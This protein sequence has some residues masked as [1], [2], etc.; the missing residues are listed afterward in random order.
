MEFLQDICEAKLFG[1]GKSNLT[2]YSA[3]Q[4]TEMLYMQFLGMQ[5]LKYESGSL[6]VVQKYVRS[7]GNLVNYDYWRS[8]KNELYLMIH[9]IIGKYSDE[10]RHML[11]YGE[12]DADFLKRT[13][14]NKQNL[15]RFMRS[16]AS[17]HFDVGS[18]RRFMMELESGLRIT[19]SYLK[20]IRRVAANWDI[21]SYTT[22]KTTLT[23]LLQLF[24]SKARRSEL[25]PY[26]ESLSIALN[27]E[28][29]KLSAI[30]NEPNPKA[31]QT[32][33]KPDMN[34]LRNIAAG[35][36]AGSTAASILA[37]KKKD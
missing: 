20:N 31:Q 23:R 10:A 4:I 13:R 33:V 24:R 34:F 17:G 19:D 21:Q 35:S 12:R 15:A 11:K 8:G 26:L 28:N 9:L 5:I 7:T 30:N 6:P 29:R 27:M 36:S 3:K 14:L 37:R 32:P 18:D 1:S 25:L 16:A 2:Q 22:K